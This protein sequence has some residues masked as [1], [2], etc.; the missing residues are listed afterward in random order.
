MIL[1]TYSP[2]D[3]QVFGVIEAPIVGT[4]ESVSLSAALPVVGIE[5]MPDY[6]W[7]LHALEDRLRRPEIYAALGE[8]VEAK[9]EKLRQWLAEHTPEE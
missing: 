8:D 5:M 6:K 2:I 3:G 1:A 7:Q 4:V 9:V